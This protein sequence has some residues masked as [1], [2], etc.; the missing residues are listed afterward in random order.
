MVPRLLPHDLPMP[1]PLTPIS[2]EEVGVLL[3]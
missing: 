2:L 3:E 1:N